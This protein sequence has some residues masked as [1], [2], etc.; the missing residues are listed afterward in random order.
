MNSPKSCTNTHGAVL[1]PLHS[2]SS[3]SF[4]EDKFL[5]KYESTGA[6]TVKRVG[7][8]PRADRAVACAS[9]PGSRGARSPCMLLSRTMLL[10][11]G[12]RRH[13]AR[14]RGKDTDGEQGGLRG[15]PVSRQL[16]AEP[17]PSLPSQCLRRVA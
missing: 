13:Q 11:D 17:S 14:N 4:V 16:G 10:A 12:H 1:K 6:H 7:F 8:H 5:P 9:A 15:R 2:F 3:L